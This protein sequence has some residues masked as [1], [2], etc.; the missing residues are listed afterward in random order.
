MRVTF[1][2]VARAEWTKIVALRSTWILLA[3]TAV[4]TIGAAAAVGARASGSAFLGMDLTSLIIGVFGIVLIT[5]EYGSGLIRATFAA[6]P[7]RLPVLS[8]KAVVLAAATVP[9]MAV[10]SVSAIAVYRAL[11]PSG[12]TAGLLRA[13]VGATAAPVLLGLLGL[14][15]G[16]LIRH[17]AAAITAYILSMLVLPALLGAALPGASGDQVVRFVPVA[18]A[19]ALYTLGDGNPVRMLAPGPAALVLIAWV[20]LA[21]AAGGATLWRRDP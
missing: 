5:G 9:V 3:F 21:L 6:V 15:V 12:D 17:T 4:L 13:T 1:A 14:G 7:R 2:R 19:Q 8:A 20:V 16:A 18:A 10:V 11:A